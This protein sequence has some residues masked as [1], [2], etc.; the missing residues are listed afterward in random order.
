[1]LLFNV[2]VPDIFVSF[3]FVIPDTFNDDIIVVILFNV[4]VPDIFVLFNVVGQGSR[5]PEMDT[6]LLRGVGAGC[7]SN[8][9]SRARAPWPPP[10]RTPRTPRIR[11]APSSPKQVRS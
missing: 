3:K 1:M 9:V 11:P 7:G 6:E 10:R 5:V 2:V 8:S 4:V